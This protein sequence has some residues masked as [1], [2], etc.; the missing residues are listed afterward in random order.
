MS[1]CQT[2]TL[3]LIH[4][5]RNT[6]FKSEGGT[7]QQGMKL[8]I[9]NDVQTAA[10]MILEPTLPGVIRHFV[11]EKIREYINGDFFGIEK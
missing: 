7:V 11:R 3:E 10:Y 9:H 4:T 6:V 2:K 5:A 1:Y 8:F